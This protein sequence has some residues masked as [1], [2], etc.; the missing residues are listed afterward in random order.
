MVEWPYWQQVIGGTWA[1]LNAF[2]IYQRRDP[3]AVIPS[4]RTPSSE[5]RRTTSKI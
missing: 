5:E 4:Q 2:G 3:G 1:W